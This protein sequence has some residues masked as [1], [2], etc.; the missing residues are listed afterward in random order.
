MYVATKGGETAIAN[1][2]AWLAEERRGDPAV[3]L[4]RWWAPNGFTEAGFP[5]EGAAIAEAGG[6]EGGMGESAEGGSETLRY[7]ARET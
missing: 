1:A 7:L 4:S 2:H 5:G 3:P 6:R